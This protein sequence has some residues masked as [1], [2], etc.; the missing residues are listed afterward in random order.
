M[1]SVPV[2]HAITKLEFGGAQQNTLYTLAALD[3]RRF[4]PVLV[5]GPEGYLMDQAREMDADLR[6]IRHM[7]RPV[8]PVRDLRAYRELVRF[9]RQLRPDD[10]GILK[11]DYILFVVRRS[12]C[13]FM[14]NHLFHP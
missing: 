13:I 12:R 10:S 1:R 11:D 5:T 4:E 9:F 8:N 7:E 14:R 2:I 3:R 6:V